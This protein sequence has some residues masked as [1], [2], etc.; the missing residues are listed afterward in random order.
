M[1]HACNHGGPQVLIRVN[2]EL[3][4][5]LV[6][7]WACVTQKKMLVK[8]PRTPTVASVLQDYAEQA[9][10][11]GWCSAPIATQLVS[12]CRDL[13]VVVCNS[14]SQLQIER[15]K[16]YFRLDLPRKLLYP[17]ERKQ[18]K[19]LAASSDLDVCDVY[20][21]EHLLRMFTTLPVASPLNMNLYF[22]F[23]TPCR[24]NLGCVSPDKPW[25]PPHGSECQVPARCSQIPVH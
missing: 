4:V 16:V 2:D 8:L 20:G 6:E 7:D 24:T 12:L 19:E 22:C 5:K 25:A 18:Y 21:P 1:Q 13:R 3:K 11:K 17:Q 9:S 10:Q 14:S 23:L 15:L